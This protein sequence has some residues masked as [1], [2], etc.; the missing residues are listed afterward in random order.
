MYNGNSPVNMNTDLEAAQS[1]LNRNAV[2]SEESTSQSLAT[3]TNGS[4]TTTT[5]AEGVTEAFA[6]L[7]LPVVANLPSNNEIIQ[8]LVVALKQQNR[9][10]SC[11][12]MIPALLTIVGGV[13]CFI[14]T[15]IESHAHEVTPFIIWT[16]FGSI[17]TFTALILFAFGLKMRFSRQPQTVAQGPIRYVMRI[18]GEQ[19]KRFVTYF[20]STVEGPYGVRCRCCCRQQRQQ[21]YQRLLQRNYGH[22]VFGSLG[23]MVDEL[24]CTTYDAHVVLNVEVLSKIGDPNN[25]GEVI[26]DIVMRVWLCQRVYNA[27]YGQPIPFK[28]DIFLASRLPA[29]EIPSIVSYVVIP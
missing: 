18:D 9:I 13:I 16:A 4:A 11:W 19:W 23:F 20:C 21:R 17:F 10:R 25:Q 7:N 24:Y 3:N 8:Q 6:L 12:I 22:I 15:S 5:A 1:L 29:Y 26:P 2:Q 14:G 28:I 27:R